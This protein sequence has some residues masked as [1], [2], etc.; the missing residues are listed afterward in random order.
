LNGKGVPPPV[1]V[2]S[3]KTTNPKPWSSV[4]FAVLSALGRSRFFFLSM[5][6]VFMLAEINPRMGHLATSLLATKAQFS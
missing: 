1:L 6:I 3:A 2:P 5:K 4:A